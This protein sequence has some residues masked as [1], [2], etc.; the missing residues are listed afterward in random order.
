[1]EVRDVK[2]IAALARLELGEAELA[3]FATQLSAILAYFEKLREVDTE[4]VPPASHPPELRGPLRADAVEPFPRAAELVR[5]S[6]DSEP[7]LYK[8][9]RVLE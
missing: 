5:A 7:E 3:R 6:Q 1:M 2:K 9:P 8:V 4:G